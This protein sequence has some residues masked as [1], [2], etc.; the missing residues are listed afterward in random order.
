M[1]VSATQSNTHATTLATGEVADLLEIHP[2]TVKRWFED[3]A[4]GPGSDAATARPG[5]FTTPGGHRRISLEL[6]LRVAAERGRETC[7]H[8]FGLDA[9]RAWQATANLD[10]GNARPTQRLLLDWLKTGRSRRIGRLLRYLTGLPVRGRTRRLDMVDPRILDGVFG[11]FMRRVGDAWAQ[12]DLEIPAERA[13]SRELTETVHA[14]L[15]MAD[16]GA[17]GAGSVRSTAVVANVEPSQHVLGSQLVQLMLVQRGW[18]VEHLGTGLPVTDIIATQRALRASLVCV[19]CAPPL[20]ASDVRRF[21]ELAGRL[22]DP[23]RPCSL[24]VGG[25]GAQ[26]VNFNPSGWPFDAPAVLGT[27]AEFDEWLSHA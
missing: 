2:S 6:V 5:V 12:G 25:S 22:A 10:A 24:V 23:A 21:V 19:S 17:P 27:L 20:G 14:L 8:G 3:G 7:F 4:R 1:S 16:D 18:R 13:A 26:G 11:G 9:A 15:D